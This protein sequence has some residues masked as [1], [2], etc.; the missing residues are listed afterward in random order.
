MEK[1]IVQFGELRAEN[2]KALGEKMGKKGTEGLIFNQR[3]KGGK[4]GQTTFFC[5]YGGESDSGAQKRGLSP[6]PYL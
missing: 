1:A 2:R 5:C 4:G 6:N 3:K